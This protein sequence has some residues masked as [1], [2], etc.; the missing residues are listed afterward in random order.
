[1][2]VEEPMINAQDRKMVPSDIL[3]IA[4]LQTMLLMLSLSLHSKNK[5]QMA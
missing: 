3:Q 2:K 4:Y 5:W 1:M